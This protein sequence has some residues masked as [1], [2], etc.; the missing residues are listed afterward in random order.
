MTLS[1]LTLRVIAMD[2]EGELNGEPYSKSNRRYGSDVERKLRM[3]TAESAAA[4]EV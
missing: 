1:T 2:S 3:E 4:L